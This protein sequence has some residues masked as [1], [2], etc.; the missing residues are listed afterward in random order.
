[1][2]DRENRTVLSE[3]QVTGSHLTPSKHAWVEQVEKFVARKTLLATTAPL[4][5]YL[6]DVYLTTGVNAGGE[7]GTPL[8]SAPWRGRT[9]VRKRG[10]GVEQGVMFEHLL[11]SG[12]R[13]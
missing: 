6:T 4:P 1:M 10:T 2:R 8:S 7:P 13:P 11:P 9:V 5:P 3:Q 12:G